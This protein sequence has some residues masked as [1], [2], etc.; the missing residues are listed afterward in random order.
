MKPVLRKVNIME[1]NLKQLIEKEI[2]QHVNSRLEQYKNFMILSIAEML[3]YGEINKE[4]SELLYKHNYD[5]YKSLLLEKVNAFCS[6]WKGLDD[7]NN[8]KLKECV[9]HNS[10]KI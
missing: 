4:Q 6:G 5:V 1:N 7:C 2:T 9:H 3:K 8:C 10:R